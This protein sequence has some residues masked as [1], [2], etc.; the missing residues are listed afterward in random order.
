MRTRRLLCL[1]LLVFFSGSLAVGQNHFK[2]YPTRS[3]TE[4]KPFTVGLKDQFAREPMKVDLAGIT[5]FANPVK[6]TYNGVT[7]PTPNPNAHLTW[8]KFMKPEMTGK[9]RVSFKNQF[10]EQRCE[11]A[12]AI[13]LLVPTEKVEPGSSMP[14]EFNHFKAYKVTT[15]Q[16]SRRRVT[17]Q[18]Q[19]DKRPV[20]VEVVKLLFFLNPVSKNGEPIPRP[21]YHLACYAT[22]G[23][24]APAVKEVSIKNQFGDRRL[25]PPAAPTMICVPTEKLRWEPIR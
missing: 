17:L 13:F 22:Q 12:E 15:Q 10:G 19:W 2:V 23:G 24:A 6:K 11:L 5:F 18:D 14:R 4:F 20:T 1:G 7:S 21:G 16:F 3:L 8:Y 25:A 9:R